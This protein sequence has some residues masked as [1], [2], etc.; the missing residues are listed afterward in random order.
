MSDKPQE[1]EFHLTQ[2][3]LLNHV[4]AVRDSIFQLFSSHGGSDQ[5]DT[6]L[7]QIVNYFSGRSQAATFLVGWGYNWDSE[8]I[9]RSFYE[10]GSKLWFICF[11]KEEFRAELVREFWTSLQST[12]NYKRRSRAEVC[13]KSA[14]NRDFE[15]VFQFLL[16]D[17]I[18]DFGTSNKAGRRALA[19]KWSFSEIIYALENGS[20]R[21]VAVPGIM[22][23]S[24]VYSL[25]SHLAHADDGALDFVFDH[26]TRPLEEAEIK[27]RAHV[28][29]IV[30][31]IASLWLLSYQAIQ[32]HFEGTMGIDE[33]IKRRFE[34]LNALIEPYQEA[35][36]RSQDEF[37]S[38]YPEL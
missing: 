34:Y 1:F 29:R 16:R 19:Q 2:D 35:F 3:S 5:V 7:Y 33:E 15:R 25:Q 11:H 32:F 6:T 22:T 20:E 9:L 28:C 18:F 23:L 4:S 38:K 31:D 27:S 14:P 21:I 26:Q 12:H 37:Y 13:V 24:Y 17:D 36:H 10:A 30:S 8:I